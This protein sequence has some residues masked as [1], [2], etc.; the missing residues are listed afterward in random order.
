MGRRSYRQT[1]YAAQAL[2]RVGERWTLLVVRELLTGP[3]RFKDLQDALPGMGPNLLSA[4]LQQ[5]E[6][7][8]LVERTQLPPPAGAAAWAL[9]EF[10]HELE[11]VLLGLVRFG[12]SLGLRR[13]RSHHSRAGWDVLAA[14]ALFEPDTAR[15]A[16]C[17]YELRVGDE[18]FCFQVEE[19]ELTTW[20][21]PGRQP[22]AV[23]TTDPETW[24]QLTHGE[25]SFD[26]ALED[27]RLKLSGNRRA[28]RR[29]GTL[30]R[31]RN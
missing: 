12:R 13:R 11:P 23:L 31:Q 28:A 3:R 7:D 24:Q 9:T 8:G 15:G 1:C 14:R 18:V 6:S 20:T 27:D 5:L 10:G 22:D 25:R 30:F 4:R 21:G 16:D 17:L 26:S 19:G 29:L 2:D